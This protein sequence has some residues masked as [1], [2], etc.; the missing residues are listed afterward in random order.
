[1]TISPFCWQQGRSMIGRIMTSH[2]LRAL[3]TPLVL[4]LT[5][6]SSP[7]QATVDPLSPPQQAVS[8]KKQHELFPVPSELQDN[9]A[10]WRSVFAHWGRGQVAIHDDE[11]LGLIY[12]VYDVPGEVT[13]GLSK[14]QRAQVDE[15]AAMWAA[16]LERLAGANINDDTLTQQD[17]DL[18]KRIKAVGG[19]QALNNAAS[20]VRT[21]RGI[22]ER[23]LRGLEI[24]GRYDAA[25]RRAFKAEGLPEDLAYLPHVESSFQSHAKSTVG[26]TGMWQFTR[27][28]GKTYM[29]VTRTVD[30]RLDPIASA[31]GA[32]RYLRDSYDRL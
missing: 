32:A 21:Q 6:S 20:R 2:N 19:P 9:I 23:F 16:R 26:A 1:M 12:E 18:I 29:T 10:F 13:E 3:L 4:A 14:T 8:L 25:F 17:R 28:A 7:L 11:H 27:G 15:R 30:E 31:H 24:S 22:R 5:L